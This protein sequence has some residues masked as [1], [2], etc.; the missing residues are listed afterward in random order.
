M[1]FVGVTLRVTLNT[2]ISSVSIQYTTAAGGT[3]TATLSSGQTITVLQNSTAHVTG[4]SFSTGYGH[5]VTCTGSTSWSMTSNFGT[6]LDE[7]LKMGTTEKNFAFKPT[8]LY[9]MLMKRE[10]G[11]DSFKLTYY[12]NSST[13]K[14]STCSTASTS[15]YF[16]PGTTVSLT[17]FTISSGYD[18]PVTVK[19]LSTNGTYPIDS[20]SSTKWSFDG[21]SPPSSSGYQISASEPAK[22]YLTVKYDANGGSG[23]PTNHIEYGY[24]SSVTFN[25]SSTTPTRTG[26]DF[27]G[28]KYNGTTYRSGASVTLTGSTTGGEKIYTFTA[29]WTAISVYKATIKFN[30]NGGSNAP[31]SFIVQ[32]SSSSISVTL[33]S[34]Q[35]TRTGYTFLYWKY[36]NNFYDPGDTLTVTGSTSGNICTF[37]AQWQ[38]NA[39]VITFN[40]QS[41][42]GGTNS[43]NAI[44][45]DTVPDISVPTRPGYS[46]GGYFTS[47]GGSGTK[48]YDKDGNGLVTWL[49]TSDLILYAYWTGNVYT[50]TLNKAGGSG[51]AASV[52]ATYGQELQDLSSSQ[53]PTKDGYTFDG[54]YTGENGSGTRYY[55]SDGSSTS[56]VWNTT[57]N[58]TLYASWKANSTVYSVTVKFVDTDGSTLFNS[59]TGSAS[60]QYISITIPSTYKPTKNGYTFL[61]WTMEE[62]SNQYYAGNTYDFSGAAGGKTHTLIA[63]WEAIPTT[64][65]VNII[66]DAN[67][68]T[69]SNSSLQYQGASNPI[70]VELPSDTPTH[71]NGLTFNGWLYNGNIY[72]PGS[73]YAFNG[74]ASG[75]TYTLTAI[76]SSYVVSLTFNPGICMNAVNMPANFMITGESNIISGEIPAEIP[77]APG[78]TFQYWDCNGTQYIPGQSCTF[79][80]ETSSAEYEFIAIYTPNTYTITFYDTGEVVDVIYGDDLPSVTPP[81]MQGSVF[82]GYYTEI[83]GVKTF[84]YDAE[85]NG[86]N[87]WTIASN[88][89]LYA[90]WITQTIED[91]GIYINRMYYMPYIFYNGGWQQA[92]AY[93]YNNGWTMTKKQEE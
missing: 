81:T 17:S 82:N 79:T 86:V 44:Y 40:K 46:F 1:A 70:N 80:L 54:Y 21:S 66:F 37:V 48:Y 90:Y 27:A 78:Y 22:Y 87:P 67:G 29:Q 73:A 31:A 20:S 62:N 83:D 61:Y 49:S 91:G 12:L 51:G 52:E 34:G 85:G 16:N 69:Y 43:I 6:F 53:L 55:Y 68:G 84:W 56:T 8:Q 59:Q 36:N 74:S 28:W 10:T 9:Q 89:T 65:Y 76:W 19:N 15:F 25:L 18:Y 26:Y 3:D 23:S 75:E 63:A 35:P 24:S 58:G 13:V 45:G 5:P 92:K 2:G 38:G 47:A 88:A 57:G 72:S 42:S 33:P 60:T 4:F 93:I 7:T 32:N 14:T 77:E 11:I 64:Y 30:A 71:P 50:I 41:G 39:N